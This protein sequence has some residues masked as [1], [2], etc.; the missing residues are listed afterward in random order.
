MRPLLRIQRVIGM[1]VPCRGMGS[2]MLRYGLRAFPRR[3]WSSRTLLRHLRVPGSR[4]WNRAAL[5]GAR[6]HASPLGTCQVQEL[7]TRA[8]L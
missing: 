3:L 6:E 4:A 7:D 5:S 8:E 1:P 2:E